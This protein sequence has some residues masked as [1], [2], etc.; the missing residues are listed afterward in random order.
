MASVQ[1]T[2][3]I[4]ID[5][6]QVLDG[7]AQLETAELERFVE[8]VNFILAKRKSSSLPQHE[9]ELLQQIHQGLPDHIQQ[10]YN[11]LQAKQQ[12]ETI[13]A[14]EHQ[15]LLTLV[16]TVEQA[17]VDRLQHLIELAQL[18]Q[19]SLPDLMRQL[20]IEIPPVYA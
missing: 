3:Q 1:V 6:N 13:T 7:V 19:V 11:D 10:R 16:D 20:D 9:A 17:D 8:Q 12:A 15:M 5:L 14:E 4:N 2:S 18:R